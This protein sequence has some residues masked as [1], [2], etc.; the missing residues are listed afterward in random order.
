M[1]GMVRLLALLILLS[2]LAAQAQSY[3]DKAVRVVVGF[4]PGGPTDVI[5]RIVAQKLS[6]TWGQQFFIENVPGA[7]SNIASGMVA[8]APP[9][10]YTL[11]VISTGFVVNPSLYAKVPYDAV[12][13]FAPITLVAASPNV[14]SVNPSV[15]AKTVQELIALIRAAPGKYSFAGPGIGSTPH[16]SGELF[17]IRFGL[18]LVHVPFAGAAP[19]VEAAIAG[20]VPIVFSALPPAIAAIKA[21]QLRALAVTA[22]HR[23]PSLPDVPTMAE[24]G[25]ADQE[26][27][28]L[29]GIL[30]PAGTPPEIVDKLYREI[31]RVVALPDVNAKLSAV[32][33]GPVV[34]TPD[35]FAVRIKAELTKWQK[36]VADAKIKVE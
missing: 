6:E 24:S 15:P 11:L 35:E 12:K 8:K 34:D 16:L 26:A 29:T 32:G 23:V 21:G 28:T 17:R 3:P 25:I 31:K 27:D 20:H 9:D 4:T 7:G 33:F 13:D 10:G 19:A 18:D 30:A 5:A 2:P 14:V 36:V 22:A 1:R